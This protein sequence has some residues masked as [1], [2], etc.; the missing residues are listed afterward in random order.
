MDP[1]CKPLTSPTKLI[2]KTGYQSPE[3]ILMKNDR[4]NP[5]TTMLLKII[6]TYLFIIL[7]LACA[8]YEECLFSRIFPRLNCCCKLLVAG[9]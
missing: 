4:N 6:I 3:N 5:H 1:D 8:E 2:E 9:S 7:R